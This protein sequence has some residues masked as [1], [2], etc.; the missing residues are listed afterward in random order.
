M[1]KDWDTQKLVTQTSGVYGLA[2]ICNLLPLAAHQIRYQVRAQTNSRKNMGIW[3]DK[4]LNLFMVDLTIFCP[5]LKR[6][7][8]KEFPQ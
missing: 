6:M 3:M 7:L 2:G 4:N 5:W 1:P 8:A